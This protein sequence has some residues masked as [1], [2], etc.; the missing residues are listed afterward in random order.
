MITNI[1]KNKVLCPS[2]ILCS[3]NANMRKGLHS[4]PVFCLKKNRLF[5]ENSVFMPL[6]ITFIAGMSTLVGAALTFIIKRNDVKLLALGMSFSAGVMIYLCFMDVM[7]LAVKFAASEAEEATKWPEI[8]CVASFFLGGLLAG[9][10]DWFVPE[11]IDSDMVGARGDNGVCNCM[12]HGSLRSGCESCPVENGHKT[13][14]KA[15]CNRTARAGLITAIALGIHNFPEGLSVFATSLSDINI[16]IAVGFAVL[17]HNIPEGISVALPVYNVTGNK[18][19]AFMMSALSGL[20]E[21][22]GAICAWLFL[23]PFLTPMLLG[24]I[25][26]LTAGIMIYISLDE[27]LPMAKEYGHEH[28]GIV[29]VFLGMALMAFSGIIFS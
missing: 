7:P 8:I 27:L 10:I 20:A 14:L 26:A 1:S 19:K 29:G 17:L 11:H 23:S 4:N 12:N 6:F 16:G 9:A 22:V 13:H 24:A 15:Q 28:Y 18:K 5:M 2:S 3:V 21:P 25:L